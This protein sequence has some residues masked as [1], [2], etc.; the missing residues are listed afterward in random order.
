MIEQTSVE[1]A[2]ARLGLP[3]GT[4]F[5]GYVVHLPKSDEFLAAQ[6][7][8]KYQDGWITQKRAWSKTPANAMV[9]KDYYE[10]ELLAKSYGKNA[11]VK[12]LFDKGD[13]YYVV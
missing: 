10:A 13:E 8:E 5:E 3:K 2:I 9:L 11:E 12:R 4:T 7:D 1:E 6:G